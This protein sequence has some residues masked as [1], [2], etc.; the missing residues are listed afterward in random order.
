MRCPLFG[1]N[2]RRELRVRFMR[3]DENENGAHGQK[4]PH[5][6]RGA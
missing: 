3:R 6:Q 5:A 2:Q 4:Q 1:L